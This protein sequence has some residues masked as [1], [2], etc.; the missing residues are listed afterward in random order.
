VNPHA[1]DTG[2]RRTPN[3]LLTVIEEAQ[4]E[5]SAGIL[6]LRAVRRGV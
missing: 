3:E 1:A 4:R 2:D 6:A 5:I